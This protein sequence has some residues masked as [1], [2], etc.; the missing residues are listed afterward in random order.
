MG[1]YLNGK[2][3]NCGKARSKKKAEQIASKKMYSELTG[4]EYII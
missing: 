1:I 3:M 2:L 4:N